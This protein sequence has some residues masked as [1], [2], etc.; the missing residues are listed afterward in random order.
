[1]LKE[2]NADRLWI[3]GNERGTESEI[4][5]LLYFLF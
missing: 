5:V 3:L 1:M 2:S 4:G